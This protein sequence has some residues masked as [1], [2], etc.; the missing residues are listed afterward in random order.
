MPFIRTRWNSRLTAPLSML[1]VDVRNIRE[2]MKSSGKRINLMSGQWVLKKT[3]VP[4]L[5]SI[6]YA[7][8]IRSAVDFIHR[9]NLIGADVF[10][11]S[12]PPFC[13]FRIQ[14][15][16]L[17]RDNYSGTLVACHRQRR[18]TKPSGISRRLHKETVLTLRS[19]VSPGLR[20]SRGV[21]DP[22]SLCLLDSSLF[23]S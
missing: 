10:I 9:K 1:R 23:F 13:F 14:W 16:S 3:F 6:Y 21:T 18:R 7:S 15:S 8:E 4:S 22:Y 19:S 17:S 20:S 11:S 5:S 12:F 2:W